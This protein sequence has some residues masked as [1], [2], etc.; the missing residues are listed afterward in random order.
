ML[1]LGGWTCVVGAYLGDETL[2]VEAVPLITP[3]VAANLRLEVRPLDNRLA[4][5]LVHEHVVDAQLEPRRAT[6]SC[7]PSAIAVAPTNRP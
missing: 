2:I 3:E 6:A 7:H 1:R 5:R 4:E